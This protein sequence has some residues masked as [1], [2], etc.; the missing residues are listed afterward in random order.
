MST[1]ADAE[2]RRGIAWNFGAFVVM[3]LAGVALNLAIARLWDAA[4]LGV[5]NQVLTFHIL[6]GQ[7]AAFGIH[8]SVLKHA[9]EHADS[10]GTLRA[11]VGAALLLVV[12]IALAVIAAT[13][14]A[15]RTIA[16]LL[17]S[18]PVRL[19]LVAILPAIALFAVNKLLANALNALRAMRLFAISQA[20]RP[21]LLLVGAV[22]L[23][24][25]AQPASALA[26][27]ITAT[28][29]VLLF[30]L[31]GCVIATLPRA[32]TDA[33]IG[34]WLRTHLAFG[35]KA[36]IAGWIAET[37][38]RVDILVLGLFASDRLVGIYSMASTLVEGLVQLPTVIRNN[39]NP[40]I[41]RLA[42]AG[43]R[44]ELRAL[45]ARN[46]RLAAA[47]MGIAG[48]L[49]VLCYPLFVDWIVGD[50]IYREAWPAFAL[51]CAGLAVGAWMMPFDSFL[52]Q[53][54]LPGWQ[55]MFKLLGLAVSVIALVALV[56]LLGMA[57]AGLAVAITFVATS[58]ALQ[59]IVRRRLSA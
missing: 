28:E 58:L 41:T 19:G 47:A 35:W 54:G 43:D 21:L 27:T 22:L 12:P 53:I 56:P 14:L 25:T 45:V 7:L 44:A 2:F 5:M 24:L 50:P 15:A 46:A 39:V 6:L 26:W 57:G 10:P 4:A 17:D 34:A 18:E 51:A 32:R 49:A 11:L 1:L 8:L 52:L 59:I 13:G 38:S 36:A 30:W 40:L 55:T 23:G 31:A 42:V 37:T 9:A 20:A 16:N 33:T 29:T 48:I 3:A